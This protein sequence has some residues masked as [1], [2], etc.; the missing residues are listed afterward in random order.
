MVRETNIKFIGDSGNANL[1]T[2]EYELSLLIQQAAPSKFFFVSRDYYDLNN[3]SP[4]DTS[5]YKKFIKKNIAEEHKIFDST[6]VSNS[7]YEMQRYL[8][9]KKGFYDAIVS[10]EYEI[11]SQQA[12]TK[13]IVDLGNQFRVGEVHYRSNHPEIQNILEEIEEDAIV[14]E[15]TVIDASIFDTEKERI[16]QALQNRG[17][18]NFLANNITIKGDSSDVSKKIDILFDLNAA[19]DSPTFIKYEIGKINVFTDFQQDGNYPV[20]PSKVINGKNYFSRSKNFVVKPRAIDRQIFIKSGKEYNREQYYQTIKKLSELSTYR[21]VK[22]APRYDSKNDSLINYDIYLTPYQSKYPVDFGFGSFFSTTNSNQGQR[23][24][25][26]SADG[27]IINRNAFGGSEKNETIGEVGLEFQIVP[28][29]QQRILTSNAIN[30]GLSNTTTVPRQVDYAGIIGLI[31]SAVEV[32]THKQEQFEVATNTNFKVGV[33]HQDVINLY[34]ITSFAAGVSYDYEPANNWTVTLNPTGL[35]LLDY[36]YEQGSIWDSLLQQSPLLENSFKS[37]VLSGLLFKEISFVYNKPES[38][39][40]FSWA[41]YGGFELSGGEV[42]LANLLYNAISKS[43]VTFKISDR[44]EFAKFGKLQLD[45]RCNKRLN[46]RSSLAGRVNFG[47]ARPY[48]DNSAVPYIKQFFVG[49]QN[50]MRAWQARELGPGGY[51]E[52]LRNPVVGER[53][54]QTGDMRFETNI[55]YRAKLIGILETALFM[56]AGNVWTLEDDP[57]RPNAKFDNFYE[58]LAIG[59]GWGLRIDWTYF[60]LRLDIAYRLK[61]PY[62]RNEGTPLETYFESPIGQSFWGSPQLG[63]NY[64]F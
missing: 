58:Q 64:P 52:R 24:I 54:Y 20:V 14:K 21:F 30:L 23:L 7:A 22:L 9:N 50:S 44:L 10:S 62:L 41:L 35:N 36:S 61:N 49:G 27:S 51:A 45:W 8:Q 28:S 26:F 46:E 34:K 11:N 18:A 60:I 42:H 39:N 2:L 15:G 29:A 33:N 37:T 43:N 31:Y 32:P 25:G 57:S 19:K 1:N 53:F 13:F 6:I 12:K 63:I 48:A 4:A 56:D 17:Y 16:F 47:L 5:W 59:W 38:R 40:G 3:Q 55:E